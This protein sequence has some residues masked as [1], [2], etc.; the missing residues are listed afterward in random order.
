MWARWSGWSRVLVEAR[1]GRILIV[2]ESKCT[3]NSWE[4][5]FL[6]IIVAHSIMEFMDRHSILGDFVH[7]QFW[8]KK[9]YIEFPTDE[10][11]FWFLQIKKQKQFWFW[12][13]RVHFHEEREEI[14][15]LWRNSISGELYIVAKSTFGSPRALHW[16]SRNSMVKLGNS[17][18]LHSF[19]EHT[20]SLEGIH[21][22]PGR[23]IEDSWRLGEGAVAGGT[24]EGGRV[25]TRGPKSIERQQKGP[26]AA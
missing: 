7:L 13:I 16:S 12:E 23:L 11:T 20:R 24:R 10:S 1:E 19:R 14:G 15:F 8:G 18:A 6:E 3:S 9:V 22:S 4:I 25:I 21:K 26:R 17:G 5:R 2:V